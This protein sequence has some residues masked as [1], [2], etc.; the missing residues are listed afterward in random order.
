MPHNAF[1]DPLKEL[2]QGKVIGSTARVMLSWP[3]A[4]ER[5]SVK[6]GS[7]LQEPQPPLQP[8]SASTAQ[9]PTTPVE[10][11]NTIIHTPSMPFANYQLNQERHLRLLQS[12]LDGHKLRA[13]EF[14]KQCE[15]VTAELDNTKERYS[16]AGHRQFQVMHLTAVG[17]TSHH[18]PTATIAAQDFLHRP[19]CRILANL[20]IATKLGHHQNK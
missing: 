19:C 18:S 12:Q 3:S 16:A 11:Y 6:N 13:D 7:L 14:E 4:F 1:N 5:Q 10:K 17:A 9:A 8:A 2:E 15:R 20:A